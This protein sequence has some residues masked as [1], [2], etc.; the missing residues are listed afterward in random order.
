MSQ[1]GSFDYKVRHATTW[2]L[3]EYEIDG[4]EPTKDFIRWHE[5]KTRYPLQV[6]TV[7]TSGT[8]K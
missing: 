5:N 4:R 1:I 6:P 3:T 8:G 7:P 2:T